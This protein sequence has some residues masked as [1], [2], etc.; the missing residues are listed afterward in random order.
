MGLV[1]R[2]RVKAFAAGYQAG[3]EAIFALAIA[4]GVGFWVDT[5][6]ET[7]PVFLMVGTAVG[8]SACVLRLLRYQRV[9]DERQGDSDDD[10]TD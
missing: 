4:V 10:A 2:Y 6:Y 5:R 9:L 7:Q 1:Q 8:L 3:L